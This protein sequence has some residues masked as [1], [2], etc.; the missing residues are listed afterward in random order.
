MVA[1][2]GD[3]SD[4]LRGGAEGSGEEGGVELEVGWDRENDSSE[5]PSST[6][7]PVAPSSRGRR[8]AGGT[9]GLS[10]GGVCPEAERQAWGPGV[11]VESGPGEERGRPGRTHR[12]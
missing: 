10:L 8:G 12:P 3:P 1:V 11:R 4:L 6:Q 5:Q 2:K 9:S 7:K